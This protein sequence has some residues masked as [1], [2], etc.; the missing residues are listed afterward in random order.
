MKVHCDCH[1]PLPAA[2]QAGQFLLELENTMRS[3][4]G[5]STINIGWTRELWDLDSFVWGVKTEQESL[6]GWWTSESSI[7]SHKPGGE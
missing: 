7:T 1:L 6:G 5:K 3:C 4:Q 2:T